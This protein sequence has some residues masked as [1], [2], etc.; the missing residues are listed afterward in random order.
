MIVAHLLRHLNFLLMILIM[1]T[2][3]MKQIGMLQF[4]HDKVLKE[5]SHFQKWKE[6]CALEM[7]K[8][9]AIILAKGICVEILDSD[10]CYLH[11]FFP[12]VM[13]RD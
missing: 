9:F 8:F 1:K 13:S 12:S 6:T 3:R 11:S 5:K 7:K 10:S 2:F 4:L